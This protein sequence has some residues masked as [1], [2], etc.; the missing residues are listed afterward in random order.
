MKEQ[1]F[2]YRKYV[3]GGIAVVIVLI[4]IARLAVLQLASD[5][6]A[7]SAKSNALLNNVLYPSRGLIYDRNGQLLVYNQPTYDI[8]VVT[9]EMEDLDTLDFCHTI[10]ITKKDFDNPEHPLAQAI[11]MSPAGRPAQ[12]EEIASVITF[13]CSDEAFFVQGTTITADGG[14]LMC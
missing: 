12:P 4:Y 13:L 5:E 1:D 9:N 8:M 11:A 14:A 10:N 3:L 6:Y 2:G 7:G